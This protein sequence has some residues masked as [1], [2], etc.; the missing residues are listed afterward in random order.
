MDGMKQT[1]RRKSIGSQRNPE[2]RTAVLQAARDIMAN[3]GIAK[4]SIEAVA[5]QARAGKP[6]IYKWWNGKAG[7][8]LD[9]HQSTA[10][11]VE[12]PNAGSL[13]EDIAG[14]LVNL[15]DHW[16]SDDAGDIFRAVIAEAQVDQKSRTAFGDYIAGRR[17]ALSAMVDAAVSRGEISGGADIDVLCDIL[18]GL[19]L[20]R[21]LSGR[22]LS[23]K[24][25]G[26]IADVVIDGIVGQS[27]GASL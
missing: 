2:T 12:V 11:E 3:G 27:N 6:T 17:A 16:H 22:D 10:P 9:L 21:L 23:V 15:I 18:S 8:L 25:A 1:A 4:F 26:A 24:E 14:F 13:R 7:L 19:A 20:Q 5:R